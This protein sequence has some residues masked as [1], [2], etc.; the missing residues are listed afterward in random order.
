MTTHRDDHQATD[1]PFTTVELSEVRDLLEH[2]IERLRGELRRADH[3]FAAVTVASAGRSAHEVVDVADRHVTATQDAGSTANAAVILQQT[4]HALRR[5]DEG[6]YGICDTCG[7]P[8]GRLRLD[9]FPRA[10]RCLGC[11]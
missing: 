1:D 7:G 3:E 9:A 11:S 5:L 4:E 2:T 6:L 8:I 10:A